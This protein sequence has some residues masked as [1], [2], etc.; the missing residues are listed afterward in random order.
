MIKR[1]KIESVLRRKVRVK[2]TKRKRGRFTV[3]IP[4]LL[5]PGYDGRTYDVEESFTRRRDALTFLYTKL[6]CVQEITI[7]VKGAPK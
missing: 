5:F 7:E 6:R 4:A 3:R 1:K 2:M